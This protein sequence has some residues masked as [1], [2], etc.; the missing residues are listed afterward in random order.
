VCSLNL[1]AN[2]AAKSFLQA[3]PFSVVI[4]HVC[5]YFSALTPSWEFLESHLPLSEKDGKAISIAH[6]EIS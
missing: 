2:N 3:A 6:I 5:V 1:V 4:K